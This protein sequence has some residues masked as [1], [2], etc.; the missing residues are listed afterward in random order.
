MSRLIFLRNIAFMPCVEVAA[1]YDHSG[2]DG[3]YDASVYL[4]SLHRTVL[5]FVRYE[6]APLPPGK[7]ERIFDRAVRI[8]R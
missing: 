5:L 1:P 2:H 8:F 7:A 3:G 6:R 4:L